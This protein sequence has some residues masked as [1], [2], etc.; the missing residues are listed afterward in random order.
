MKTKLELILPKMRCPLCGGKFQ[1]QIGKTEKDEVIEGL[2]C[3][4]EN[5]RFGIHAGVVDFGSQEQ[6]IGN[7]WSK[8]LDDKS[9]EEFDKEIED[10]K[11]EKEKQEQA[12]LLHKT[13][14]L[15]LEKKPELVIDIASG[16]GML[17][18]TLLESDLPDNSCTLVATDLSF[19]ILAKD[20]LKFKRRFPDKSLVYIACDA[21]NLP[22]A[23]DT[24]DVTVSFFGIFNMFN[25]IEKGIA[26]AS[27]VTK[28]SGTLLNAFVDIKEDSEGY[29]KTAEICAQNNMAGT[30]K[31]CLF[32]HIKSI[33][34]K[35][36]SELTPITVVESICGESEHVGDLL[37]Y[38]GEWYA[39]RVYAGRK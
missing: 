35:Y 19:E 21:T 20:R 7:D 17:L 14:D 31:M 39:Y 8:Y 38:S 22:F 9:P 4:G 10:A 37:P 16:R 13:K 18:S 32:D 36:F 11:S 23:D 25:L 28:S 1:L 2:L 30:E 15:V 27:R 12:A 33:H 24:A 3:C 34:E 5:H 26:E 29:A 6:E